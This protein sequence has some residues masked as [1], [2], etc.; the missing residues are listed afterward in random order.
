MT[1]HI[2]SL[3]ALALLAAACGGGGSAD[4]KKSEDAKS[5]EPAASSTAPTGKVIEILM[6]TDE[7]GNYFE[8][9]TFEAEE[10]DVLRFKLVTG[11]HN[12]HF[13]AD[14][15]PGVKGLP[16]MTAFLQLPGQTVDVPLNF[17]K[18]NF[19]FQC[20]PHA[21]LGMVGRVKVDD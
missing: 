19:Y 11:V 15:N 18:G 8:P 13:V 21:M 5:D 3:I 7:K 2:R 1:R 17:G 20:D 9:A 10:G 16:A 4:D 12:V 14:S 6:H